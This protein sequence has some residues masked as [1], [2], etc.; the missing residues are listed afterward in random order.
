[1]ALLGRLILIIIGY[2]LAAIAGCTVG[3]VGALHWALV[4]LSDHSGPHLID[5]ILTNMA[6]EAQKPWAGAGLFTAMVLAPL[7][8][9]ALAAVIGEAFAIRGWLAWAFGLA[10]AFAAIPSL[11]AHGNPPDGAYMGPFGFLA[12]GLATGTVYWLIAGRG[13]GRWHSAPPGGLAKAAD[14]QDTGG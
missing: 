6:A 13:A 9:L 2:C 12:A 10:V 1:M 11:M 14:G 8:L 5:S 7:A 3:L 4:W